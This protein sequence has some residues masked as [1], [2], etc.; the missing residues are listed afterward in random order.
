MEDEQDDFMVLQLKSGFP[1]LRINHGSGE[2]KLTIDGR[3]R[4]GNVRMQRLNDGFWH[5][6]DIFREGKVRLVGKF[7]MFILV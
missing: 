2:T 1:T 4:A 6:I 3:D 5:K 7:E